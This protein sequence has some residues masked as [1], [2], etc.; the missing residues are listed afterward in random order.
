MKQKQVSLFFTQEE[1]KEAAIR[2]KFLSK[3]E[4]TTFYRV[5]QQLQN[6]VSVHIYEKQEKEELFVIATLGEGVDRLQEQYE[7]MGNYVMAYSIECLGME[8]LQKAYESI[9]QQYKKQGYYV[10]QF[11]YPG[12]HMPWKEME[13]IFLLVNQEEVRYNESWVMTPKKSVAMKMILTTRREEQCGNI[14]EQCKRTACSSRKG[15]RE[16]R[17]TSYGYKRI[18]NT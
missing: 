7:T 3:S 17:G 13:R 16:Q 11:L 8:L 5:Y 2:H 15:K 1:I 10:K 14:C 18:F 9:Q 12:E 4:Q 6:V